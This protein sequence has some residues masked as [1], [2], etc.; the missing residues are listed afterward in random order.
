MKAKS[1]FVT[2]VVVGGIGMGLRSRAGCANQADPDQ[3]LA[4]H[5]E[6]ICDL[7]RDHVETPAKGVRKL[8]R[9]F[10]KNLGDMTGTLGSTIAMIER[11][12]NDDKHDARARLARDRINAPLYECED[13][14]K[15]FAE[16]VAEDPDALEM[17][18]RA[19]V[20]LARTIAI[21]FGNGAFTLRDLPARMMQ[22]FE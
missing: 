6:N 17:V 11:V 10:A 5:F 9:Y 14:W 22:T 16:A 19:E 15:R 21:F 7:A 18:D 12:P 20:R 3:Q 2:L 1:W 13:D 4:Q 8:G